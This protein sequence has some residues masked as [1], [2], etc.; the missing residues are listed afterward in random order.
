MTTAFT[1]PFG[2]ILD[3]KGDGT[4]NMIPAYAG[5]PEGVHTIMITWEGNTR[6]RI[7]RAPDQVAASRIQIGEIPAG[8]GRRSLVIAGLGVKAGESAWLSAITNSNE[9]ADQ[10]ATVVVTTM[11]LQ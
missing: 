2:I 11:P 1:E 6:L 9:V 3:S 8:T 5:I 7:F 10:R 4:G